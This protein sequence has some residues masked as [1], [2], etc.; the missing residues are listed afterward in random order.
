MSKD[1]SPAALPTGSSVLRGT[2]GRDTSRSD[3]VRAQVDAVIATDPPKLN[4]AE[5]G[6]GE[7][8]LPLKV[9][10]IVGSVVTVPDETAPVTTNLA[11]T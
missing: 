9:S 1:L 4:V 10:V 3:C 5:T 6:E 8:Q 11:I 2:G 7:I